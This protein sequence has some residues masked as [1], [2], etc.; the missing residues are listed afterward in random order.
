M[1][2][3]DEYVDM[4]MDGIAVVFTGLADKAPKAFCSQTYRIINSIPRQATDDAELTFTNTAFFISTAGV[5]CMLV[6]IARAGVGGRAD[7]EE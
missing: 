6:L 7:E 4:L 3:A 2:A 1:R 5:G